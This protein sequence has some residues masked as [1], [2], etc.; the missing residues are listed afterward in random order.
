MATP[1]IQSSTT[2]AAQF[3]IANS[4]GNATVTVTKPSGVV[5][6]DL[7]IA[8]LGTGQDTGQTSMATVPSG[9]TQLGSFTLNA[10]GEAVAVYYKVASSEPSSWNW[11]WQISGNSQFT[12]E[13]CA[14]L[15]DQYV[16]SLFDGNATASGSTGTSLSFSDSITTTLTNDLLFFAFCG[17]NTT[18]TNPSFSAYAIATNNPASWTQQCFTQISNGAG[19]SIWSLVVVTATKTLAG[20]TGVSTATSSLSIVMPFGA[21]FAVS[22]N[23]IS[24]I[25]VSDI[26]SSSD[27]IKINTKYQILVNDVIKTI[28][29]MDISISTAWVNIQ[30]S[31]AN[32]WNNLNKS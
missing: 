24:K 14:R 25:S 32:L 20:A 18:A 17:R 31:A 21:L 16:A 7:L 27:V 9:W 6:G 11:I 30:K 26:V 5:D 13:F 8:I 12:A 22:R 23:I 29:T 3:R 28:D 1:V 19:T 2:T 15:T 4:S 10:D